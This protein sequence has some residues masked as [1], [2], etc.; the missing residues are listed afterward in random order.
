MKQ[1]MTIGALLAA[2]WLTGGAQPFDYFANNWN[3]IGL[4]DYAHGSRLS[5][6][7]EL[8]LA[9][10]TPIQVRVGRELT[11]LH[12]RHDGFTA[13]GSLDGNSWTMLPTAATTTSHRRPPAT[14]AS[15]RRPVFATFA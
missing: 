2:G 7:N 13:E 1:T 14:R 15:S 11:P 4:R 10:R 8:W 6:N 9:G 12:R 5:P 3:V